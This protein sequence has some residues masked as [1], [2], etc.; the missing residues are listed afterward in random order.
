VARTLGAG[1]PCR[2]GKLAQS[3]SGFAFERAANA[4]A[5]AAEARFQADSA[6]ISVKDDEEIIGG[7][8]SETYTIDASFPLPETAQ[9]FETFARARGFQTSRRLARDA[10]LSWVGHEGAVR[11]AL[12]G[13]GNVMM[14]GLIERLDANMLRIRPQ[15]SMIGIPLGSSTFGNERSGDVQIDSVIDIFSP[16]N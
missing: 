5:Q 14:V 8:G 3:T 9:E 11:F 13:G 16:R 4:L 1:Y 15:S 7:I 2:V 10:V 12:D 6:H